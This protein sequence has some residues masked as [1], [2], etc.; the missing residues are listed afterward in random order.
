MFKVSCI[1]FY[2]FLFPLQLCNGRRTL[3]IQS[4][5]GWSGLIR[6]NSN[7]R[8]GFLINDLYVDGWSPIV[9]VDMEGE[10]DSSSEIDTSVDALMGNDTGQSQYGGEITKWDFLQSFGDIKKEAL[11]HRATQRENSTPPFPGQIDHSNYKKDE[12]RNLKRQNKEQQGQNTSKGN[13]L[14]RCEVHS[15]CA[16]RGSHWCRCV[17]GNYVVHSDGPYGG[18]KNQSRR[19]KVSTVR[20]TIPVPLYH[21]RVIHQGRNCPPKDGFNENKY[22][23]GAHNLL[24]FLVEGN[25]RKK[26]KA[27]KLASCERNVEELSE[28]FFKKLINEKRKRETSENHEEEEEE[29]D[30]SFTNEDEYNLSEN[31]GGDETRRSKKRTTKRNTNSNW[32][33]GENKCSQKKSLG[34]RKKVPSDIATPR[35][36]IRCYNNIQKIKKKTTKILKNMLHALMFDPDYK[37]ILVY[38]TTDAADLIMNQ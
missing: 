27:N 4:E 23:D 25:S 35:F 18:R 32:E 10:T 31:D 34:H 30:E 9:G 5:Y 28:N 21:P 1:V 33:P 15:G 8:K 38:L 37:G 7:L 17:Y 19:E 6:E 11:F 22:L 36:S 13:S 26:Q 20:V 29:K 16:W 24:Q 12:A 3:D 14:L 2:L